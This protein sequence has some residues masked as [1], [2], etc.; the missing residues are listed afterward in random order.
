MYAQFANSR[1]GDVSPATGVPA[2]VRPPIPTDGSYQFSRVWFDLRRYTRVS[3]SG[4][5]N[6]RLLAGGWA[7]GDPLP[8]QRRLSIGGA[9]PL[10]GYGFRHTAC[11]RDIAILKTRQTVK[12]LIREFASKRTA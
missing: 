4:R 12:A 6:L 1:S 8:L 11:N 10:T 3:P 7:A 5:V 9:D 2:S